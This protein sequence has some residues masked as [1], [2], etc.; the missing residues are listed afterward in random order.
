MADPQT[1]EKKPGPPLW[2]SIVVFIGGAVILSI[3]V[4]MLL[5]GLFSAIS[6]DAFDVPGSQLRNLDAGNYD[7]YSSTG[8]LF[9]EIEDA[10]ASRQQI[11]VVNNATGDDVRVSSGDSSVS[12]TRGSNNFVSVGTFEIEDSGTYEIIVEGSDQG[13]VLVADAFPSSF[14]E[15][16]TPVFLSI[17][18][19][20]VALLGA[21][22][23]LVG[24]VRRSRA[25]KSQTL[26]PSSFTPGQYP[27]AYQ[28]PPQF[29]QP[30]APSQPPQAPGSQPP[31]GPPGPPS[32]P[33]PPPSDGP[34]PWT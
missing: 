24:I 16:Q 6:E 7:V 12:I 25:K 17:G 8:S 13:L 30:Q 33:G 10:V 2:L 1:K 29:Q 22:M 28:Q 32:P 3:G 26:G 23:I 19:T 9:G 21:I 14:A 18:G 31:Q 34:T 15:V 4:L 11:S 20:L 5:S 27:P